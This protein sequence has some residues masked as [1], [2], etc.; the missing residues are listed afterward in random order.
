MTQGA[1]STSPSRLTM[2]AS[3]GRLSLAV[4]VNSLPGR[5][6]FQMC[7]TYGA[8]DGQSGNTLPMDTA[9]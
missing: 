7:D 2:F 8:A 9:S 5:V 6:T 3:N 4:Q 1:P